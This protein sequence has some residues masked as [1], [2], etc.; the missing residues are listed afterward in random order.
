MR[1]VIIGTGN[2]AE[3]IGR[4][5]VA[6]GHEVVQVIGRN[7]ERAHQLGYLFNCNVVYNTRYL[8]P[9]ADLYIITVTDQVLQQ[10]AQKIRLQKQIVVHTT[11]SVS[12]SVLASCSE[13]YG[14]L[15]PLQTL[16]SNVDT[17]PV[18]PVLIDAN[19][20]EV[21]EQLEAFAQTWAGSVQFAG[22]EERAKLHVASV[23]VNNF[24][25]HLFATAEKYCIDNSLAFNMLLPLM[26]ETVE[27]LSLTSPA[28]VQT[29]P[30][31]RGDEKTIAK[32]LEILSTDENLHNL[33]QTLTDSIVQFHRNNDGK[34]E[35]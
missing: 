14:V 29:G 24:A 27:R 35:V 30:A 28:F 2:V 7:L 31:V 26:K 11:A 5:I 13:N 23:F 25:N 3:V 15:Y 32:H 6:A 33:Y 21:R 16:R 19:T 17:L 22:D 10:V 18:V 8:N 4:K 34:S 20:A 12:K 1:I 9:H